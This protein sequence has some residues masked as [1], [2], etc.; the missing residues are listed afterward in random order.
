MVNTPVAPANRPVPPVIVETSTMLATLGSDVGVPCPINVASRRSPLAAMNVMLPVAEPVA[1]V[2]VA[3][4]VSV[5]RPRWVP[6]PVP[7]PFTDRIGG[8][9]TSVSTPSKE[10][11]NGSP[12]PPRASV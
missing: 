2:T 4:N 7:V 3:V 1:N 11:R 9:T 8:T 12:L 6:V 5:K 10:P